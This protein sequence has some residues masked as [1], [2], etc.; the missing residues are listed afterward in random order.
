MIANDALQNILTSARD[1]STVAE[2]YSASTVP[3]TDGFD[4]NDA[5]QCFAAVEGIVF[6]GVDYRRLVKSFGSLSR[7]ITSEINNASITFSNLDNYISDFEFQHGFEGLI[8]VIR[9]IS[10]SQSVDLAT[11]QIL[12][13]GQ[14][15]KPKSGKKAEL[16]VSAKSVLD[17]LEVPIPRRKYGPIDYKGRESTD[18]E[19]EGFISMPQTGFVSYSERVPRGGFLGALG[20]KK[21]VQRTLGYS[22]YSDLD[23][24]KP[25]A[26]VFGLM[27]I[28]GVHIGYV[29]SGTFLK[30]RTAFCEGPIEALINVR[31]T[32]LALPINPSAY[33][34]VLGE[35]GSANGP[36]DPTWIAPGYYSRTAHVRAQVVN[37]A[38]DVT[39][40]APDIA[41]VVK[42]RKLPIFDGTDWSTVSWTNNGASVWRYLLTGGD[43]FSLDTAWI[44]DT[45]CAEVFD[46]N[47]APIFNTG[48]NDFTFLE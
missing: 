48:I 16:S 27:Q 5:I 26:E 38:V 22:S 32:N 36:D 43:Y 10:R 29:D 35:I 18:P 6:M 42:G 19:F 31:S 20:F 7:S 21:T 44:D 8:L 39:D 40:P 11:S 45:A 41:A 14:C 23:A 2:I 3:T 17:S 33:A 24:N 1:C 34:W 47:A 30:L 28:L 4:P 9:L 13:A 15:E 25:V 37:T 46:Y 12:F